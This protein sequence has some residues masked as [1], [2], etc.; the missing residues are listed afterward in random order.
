MNSADY[1]P[2]VHRYAMLMCGIALLPL[3]MGALT[4]TLKAGLAF[5]DWPTSDGQFMLTYP[6]FHDWVRGATEKFCEHGHRL[7]GAL[8]GFVSIGF[9]YVTWRYERRRWIRGIAVAV[10]LSVIFQG[11]LGGGRVELRATTLA[12]I[13]SICGA[14]VF[15]SIAVVAVMTSRSWWSVSE[16]LEQVTSPV[17]ELWQQLDRLRIFATITPIFLVA[18]YLLGGW[19]RHFGGGLYEHIGGAV[20]AWLCLVVTAVIAIRTQVPWIRRAGWTFAIMGSLQVFLGLGA[21]VVRFGFA[22][23]GYVAQMQSSFQVAV[24]TAHAV[25]GMALLAS[26]LV[27]LVRCLR[28]RYILREQLGSVTK[29]DSKHLPSNR[30]VVPAYAEGGSR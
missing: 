23:L 27:V 20:I 13:H 22:P 15:A 21:F 4:T 19:L 18:Q 6:W 5:P 10:L 7:A 3:I 14:L 11:L 24:R 17:S 26:S 16:E 9:V 28:V 8:I 30:P 2:L 12:M 1:R 29:S 25:I